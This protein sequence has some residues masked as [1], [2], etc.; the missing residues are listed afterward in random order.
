M[1]DLASRSLRSHHLF[2]WWGCQYTYRSPVFPKTIW[3]LAI[4]PQRASSKHILPGLFHQPPARERS[5][6]CEMK[7]PGRAQNDATSCPLFSPTPLNSCS[8]DHPV[9]PVFFGMPPHT[10]TQ[11]VDSWTRSE[12]TQTKS[13]HDDIKSAFQWGQV[14]KHRDLESTAI[15]AECWLTCCCWAVVS[16]AFPRKKIIA[17]ATAATKPPSEEAPRALPPR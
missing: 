7:A 13:T 15:R 16:E 5:F 4:H 2:S 3:A 8:Q 14:N 6:L 17:V 12:V 1:R 10:C 11:A 9:C